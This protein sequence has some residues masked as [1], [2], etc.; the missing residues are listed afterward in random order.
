LVPVP[1]TASTMAQGGNQLSITAPRI[2]PLGFDPLSL[3]FQ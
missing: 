1:V 2:K 3:A